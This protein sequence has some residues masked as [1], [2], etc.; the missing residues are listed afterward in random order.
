MS[1]TNTDRGAAAARSQVDPDYPLSHV[2]DSARQGLWSVSIILLG[3]I[4]FTPTMLAGAKLATA[5][6][7][8]RLLQIIVL[9][10]LLLA[11]YVG[12]LS[13][14]GARTGLTT[15]LISRYTLGRAG[16]KWADLLL[17]GTQ[18]GW[19]GVTAGVMGALIA[20]ALGIDSVVT[21]KFLVILSGILMGVTAYYGY[22]GMELL[23]AVS[24]PLL[25]ILALWVTAR[26]LA[27]VGGWAELLALEPKDSMSLAAAVTVIVGT[28]ASGGTQAPNWTRFAR[29]AGV[30]FWA[31]IIAF[32]LG[33]GAM[34]F[35][36]A[37]GSTAFP[38]S[39]G[40]F[41][42]VLYQMG[43][44]VW[45]VVFLIFN[46]WT[47]NDNAAYAFGVAGAELFNVPNKKPFVVGGVAIGTLLA[48][49]GIDQA[50]IPWLVAL[51]VF[52]PPLGG[53]IIGDYLFVWKQRLPRLDRVE[54]R[55]VRWDGVLAYLA[56]TGAA[57]WSS[58]ANVLV[59]PL[60]GIVVAA[61]AVPVFKVLF[62][63]ARW[64]QRT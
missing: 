38:A 23:S 29:N 58:S 9:G 14:V 53:A 34:L 43:L 25:I 6:P 52:I 60:V 51:G 18:V 39:G 15:V 1:P 40:D 33:N 27:E 13:V 31:A 7:F 56:G 62:A 55:A 5:F 28:F 11:A 22:R 21:T 30:A 10:S 20:A 8:G 59:P 37:V 47:T 12:V 16:A 50:L 35:F 3:F 26:S 61:V 4:F 46:L 54:F 19:Y 45:G 17:G 57:Q 42:T 49:L 63:A 64:A 44:I 48:V 32:F 24:V 2:P 41:I 36:G